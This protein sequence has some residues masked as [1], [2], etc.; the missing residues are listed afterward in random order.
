MRRAQI[1][2]RTNE[3]DI[4]LSLTLDGAGTAELDTGVFFFEHM[5]RTLAK[6]GGFDLKVKARGDLEIDAHHTVEDIGIALGLAFREA[7]GDKRGI[8]RFSSAYV[9]LDEALAFACVDVSGRPFA[10]LDLALVEGKHME[11]F[12]S[13]LLAEFFRAFA[14]NAGITLH[15]TVE[16]GA[17]P[18]HMA[19]AAFKALARAL[20]GAVRVTGESIPS[21][22][23]TLG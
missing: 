6:H 4:S 14:F 18:H 19:E 13:W 20:R 10:A 15:L 11:G 8:E 7:V 9:P 16:K 17:N 5:L 1:D 21:T 3:T 23:G 12:D 2:R 22:K